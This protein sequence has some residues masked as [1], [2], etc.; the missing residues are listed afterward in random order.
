[1]TDFI[2]NALDQLPYPAALFEV[3]SHR[4]VHANQAAL[5]TARD[6]LGREGMSSGPRGAMERL[7]FFDLL[8]HAAA[9][10]CD[11]WRGY[12]AVGRVIVSEANS[13]RSAAR[14]P[15]LLL[16]VHPDD[17][18]Q[19]AE[20]DHVIIRTLLLINESTE[21][22]IRSMQTSMLEL[23]AASESQRQ[24]LNI[25]NDMATTVMDR[26]MKKSPRS[27]LTLLPTVLEG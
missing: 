3:P 19:M 12:A 26:N 10:P 2:S 22:S 17:D 16:T 1:M 21:R 15:L 18:P 4:Y 6:H 7:G 20:A 14:P 8:N 11:T 13:T 5:L 9:S 27:L 24:M 25:M 23:H